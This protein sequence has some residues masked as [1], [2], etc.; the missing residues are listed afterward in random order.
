M[1]ESCAMRELGIVG[2]GI[3]ALSL[4]RA[5][6]STH[7]VTLFEKATTPGGL[8][9]CTRVDGI[10]YHRVGGHVFNSLDG[11]TRDDFLSIAGGVAQFE[12]LVRHAVIRFADRTVHYPIENHL[13]QLAAEDLRIIVSELLHLAQ[14]EPPEPAAFPH[15]E[16]F[17]LGTFGRRLCELYFFPYNEK[18]WQGRLD[19]KLDFSEL[20][21]QV[22]EIDPAYEIVASHFADKA[23]VVQDA[24]TAPLIDAV[25]ETLRR[26]DIHL[27][28]RFAE[29]E[30]Y[31][32]DKCMQAA[33]RVAG[34]LN[35]PR[36]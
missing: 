1:T 17:L 16:A 22:R 12:R 33:K 21:H 23:Y 11:G 3:S 31:N 13:H 20:E 18:V 36:R 6:A 8:L 5:V 34:E 24:E 25:R 15:F 9:R 30:Y 4:A 7:S 29:W 28:G 10:L 27:L 35:G 2:A 32:V 26:Y 19:E 14:R